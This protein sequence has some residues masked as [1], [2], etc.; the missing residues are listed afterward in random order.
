MKEEKLTKSNLY[1]QSEPPIK[2]S[3]KCFADKID[4]LKFIKY[5]FRNYHD[6]DE[7]QA[8]QYF[9]K[10]I[11]SPAETSGRILK[12]D[13]RPGGSSLFSE[14]LA[15]LKCLGETVERVSTQTYSVN[16]LIYKPYNE[17]KQNAINPSTISFFSKDQLSDSRFSLF[18]FSM[19]LHF[20]GL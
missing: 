3:L 9:S 4:A 7:I 10:I 13:T 1:K 12:N 16:N 2:Q 14:E 11:I 6:Y 5:I 18:K 19:I 8:Y 20:L 17:L 15:L